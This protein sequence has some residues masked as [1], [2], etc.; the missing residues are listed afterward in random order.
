MIQQTQAYFPAQTGGG[1][2]G[3]TSTFPVIVQTLT[4]GDNAV[5][6]PQSKT[7][8]GVSVIDTTTG[9]NTFVNY[10]QAAVPSINLV[11]NIAGSIVNAQIY[12]QYV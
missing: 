3:N 1:G 11:I 2:G 7:V 5:T 12:V 4:D 10:K 6:L 9:F 8:V